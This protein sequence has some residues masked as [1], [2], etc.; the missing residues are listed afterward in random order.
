[1]DIT[2]EKTYCYVYDEENNLNFLRCIGFSTLKLATALTGT[3]SSQNG[4]ISLSL[5]AAQR[6]VNAFGIP[7]DSSAHLG[8]NLSAF[9]VISLMRPNLEFLSRE[10]RR[11]L[12]YFSLSLRKDWPKAVYLAGEGA[13]LNNLDWYLSKEFNLKVAKLEPPQI[14]KCGQCA[15]LSPENL[16]VNC[17]G[18]MLADI[19]I[20][21]LL[22]DEARMK[23]IR[24]LQK[25]VL[26]GAVL[27]I[28][29]IFLSLV[30][31]TRFQIHDYSSRIRTAKVYME[32]VKELKIL[33][34]GIYAREN[35]INILRQN[36]VPSCGVLRLIAKTLPGNF[37]LNELS[38]D[39][40]NRLLKMKGT[41]VSGV[42]NPENILAIFIKDLEGSLFFKNAVVDSFKTVSEIPAF[43]ITCSLAG[44]DIK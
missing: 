40:Q 35:L 38:F 36:K 19:S 12:D 34:T 24:L 44:S 30:L 16:S 11:S 18:A 3:L 37:I 1:L 32:T 29:M 33:N 9:N 22:P 5:E 14:I 4:R 28:T 2:S 41:V 6:L 25:T 20:L 21:N 13:G 10:V 31:F 7:K 39:Q 43:E 42:Q 8:E 15:D 27:S 17:L 23:K 26:K